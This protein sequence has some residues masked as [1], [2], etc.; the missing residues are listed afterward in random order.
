VPTVVPSS[1]LVDLVTISIPLKWAST[2]NCWSDF[3]ENSSYN[4]ESRVG[5][6]LARTV[7]LEFL[8]RI[9]LFIDAQGSYLEGVTAVTDKMDRKLRLI[10]YDPVVCTTLLQ[11]A[12]G[13]GINSLLALAP[14]KSRPWSSYLYANATP[15]SSPSSVVIHHSRR[16]PILAS[17]RSV[18]CRTRTGVTGIH[19][20]TT[21]HKAQ[22]APGLGTS[23][24]AR[25]E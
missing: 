21:A 15:T 20:S 6:I 22:K 7:I 16:V 5:G 19:T 24:S 11:L 1:L 10:K 23:S 8:L 2:L 25:F 17:F 13:V 12:K 18:I 3:H 9:R 14:F 4:T